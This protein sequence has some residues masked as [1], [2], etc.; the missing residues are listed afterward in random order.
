MMII[1]MHQSDIVCQGRLCSF[2]RWILIFFKIDLA[3]VY[4]Y[5]FLTS[6]DMYQFI[7]RKFSLYSFSE[8]IQY[9]FSVEDGTP[10]VATVTTKFLRRQQN[11]SLYILCIISYTN[12]VILFFGN[13]IV[14]VFVYSS[15]FLVICSQGVDNRD[16]MLCSPAKIVRTNN[17]KIF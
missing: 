15:P 3:I 12:Q 5:V 13:V 2:F 8:F 7:Y 10:N 17:I 11:V 14:S 1:L 6:L 4:S 9:Y 16:D